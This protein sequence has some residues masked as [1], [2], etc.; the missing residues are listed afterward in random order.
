MSKRSSRPN[1][2]PRPQLIPEQ[3]KA[4]FAGVPPVFNREQCAQFSVMLAKQLAALLNNR[5]QLPWI[6]ATIDQRSDGFSLHVQVLSVDD[7]SD[8]VV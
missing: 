6:T 5:T 2:P 1:I 8:A 4:Q 7:S 3:M